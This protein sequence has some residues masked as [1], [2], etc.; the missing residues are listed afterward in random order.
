MDEEF[1]SLD[2]MEAGTGFMQS[3]YEMI[4]QLEVRGYS[5]NLGARVDHFEY[6]SGK[7]KLF[8]QDFVVDKLYRYEST[9]DP[10]D[11]AIVYAISSPSKGVKG[12]YVESYGIYQDDLSPEMLERIK[13]RIH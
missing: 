6:Q 9:S 3:L 2:I 5:E 4:H 7:M 12:V 11:T 1:T 10:D 13:Q 8:P